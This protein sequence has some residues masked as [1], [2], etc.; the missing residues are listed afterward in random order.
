VAHRFLCW[1]PQGW[2]HDVIRSTHAAQDLLSYC[3][4]LMLKIDTDNKFD[5]CEIL[6]THDTVRTTGCECLEEAL[7]ENVRNGRRIVK[8]CSIPDCLNREFEI[9]AHSI[10]CSL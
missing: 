10:L 9:Y 1:Y 2:A 4:E 5:M 8:N 3:S 7:K 6:I